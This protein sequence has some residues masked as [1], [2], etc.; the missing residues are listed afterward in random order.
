MTLIDDL[1][2]GI[3][4]E[5]SKVQ[6]RSQEMLRAYNLSQE[7]RE[8]E[9]KKTAKFIEIGHL[10]YDK[11]EHQ[12]N[13]AEDLLKE[14]AKEIASLESDIGHLQTELDSL[15]VQ[16]DPDTPAS[17]RAEAKAGFNP[18]PGLECPNCHSPASRDKA[19]CPICGQSLKNSSGSDTIDVEPQRDS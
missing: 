7:I 18:T 11:Y 2:Q 16:T 4:K 13:V 17:K 8:L 6:A 19:F 1:M 10:I 12:A 15:K 14:H 9:R 5:V 3:S